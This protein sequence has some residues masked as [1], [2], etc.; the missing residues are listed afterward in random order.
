M[1]ELKAKYRCVRLKDTMPALGVGSHFIAPPLHGACGGRG[2]KVGKQLG[3]I[4][5]A[6][7]LGIIV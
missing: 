3:A 5:K 1:Y 6:L 7:I 2:C 4:Q